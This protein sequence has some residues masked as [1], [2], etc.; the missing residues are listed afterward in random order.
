MCSLPE[1][2]GV[3]TP[4]DAGRRASGPACFR[5]GGRIPLVSDIGFTFREVFQLKGGGVII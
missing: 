2:S 5:R 3:D 1:R 4:P